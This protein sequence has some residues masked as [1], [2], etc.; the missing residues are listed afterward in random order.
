MTDK[1]KALERV[2]ALIARTASDSEEEARTCAL[3]A[4]RLIREHGMQVTVGEDRPHTSATHGQQYRND[5]FFVGDIPPFLWEM[6]R[7]QQEQRDQERAWREKAR[8]QQEEARKQKREQEEREAAKK[9]AEQYKKKKEERGKK[10]PIN[11]PS[12]GP[13]YMKK[14]I[15]WQAMPADTPHK[16]VGCGKSYAR[17]DPIVWAAGFGTFRADCLEKVRDDFEFV[18]TQPDLVDPDTKQRKQESNNTGWTF[19]KHMLWTK[20]YA[21]S[22]NG[23]C[24]WCTGQYKKG[25]PIQ[26]ARGFGSFHAECWD[27]IPRNE[28]LRPVDMR[29][30]C[31]AVKDGY[32]DAQWSAVYAAA[33]SDPEYE[34]SDNPDFF[35]RDF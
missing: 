3:L 18:A 24:A 33:D 13:K 32:R 12:A 27:K 4:C 5:D 21:S 30:A 10:C 2:K 6:L 16:C 14:D 25:D 11:Q 29:K 19:C 28:P 20:K 15:R 26:W 8:A 23:T 31:T 17:G 9:K 1:K 34:S 35:D 22:Y 7:K